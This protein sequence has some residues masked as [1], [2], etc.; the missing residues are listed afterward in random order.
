MAICFVIQP[1]DSGKYDKR[2]HDVYKPAIEAA[3]LRPIESIK[4]RVY[5]CL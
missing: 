3:G 2:F 1:F 4:T 5:R